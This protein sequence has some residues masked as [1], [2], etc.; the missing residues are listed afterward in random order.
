MPS[1]TLEDMTVDQLL[2]HAKSL[3]PKASFFDAINKNPETRETTLRMLK[4]VNPSLAIPEIDAKDAVMAAVGTQNEN[5]SKL[6]RQIMERDARDNV[7][8]RRAAIREKY[9]LTEDD[10]T[11]VEK[12]LVDEKEVNLTHDM[13]ARLYVAQRQSAVPTP[14]SFMPPTYQMPEKDVWGK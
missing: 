9:K 5:I 2:A 3:E 1:K 11:N 12:M 7:R 6:E 14:A 4:K 8:D 10:V 13:A